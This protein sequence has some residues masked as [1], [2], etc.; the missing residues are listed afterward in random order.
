[1]NPV[2]S[3]L[4]RVGPL[5]ATSAALALLGAFLFCLAPS[6]AQ[7]VPAEAPVNPEV[8]A[9]AVDQM[10]QLDRLR[11]GLA[12]TLEGST[13][14]PTLDTMKEVCMPVG[15]RAAAIGKENG[16]TVRQVATKYRNPDHAPANAQ[17]REVI[18]LF[19]RHPQIQG[20]WQPSAEGQPAGVSYYRRIAVQPS[21]L[22]CHGS[23]DS[24]PAFVKERYPQDRAF[25]F[26]PG[27][28]RGMYAVFIPEVAE[29]LESATG[30]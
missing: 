9:R 12:A 17:E 14:E 7:A 22:A 11:I 2:L 13:E 27:D 6:A 15:R 8:L 3:T 23:K 25:D 30:G 20:L 21:C 19:S 26:K 18:D 5:M 10:E 24:R 29:A 16:W 1:M 4:R 28:L